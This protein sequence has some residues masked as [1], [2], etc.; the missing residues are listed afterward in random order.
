MKIPLLD[1]K[2]QYQTIKDKIEPA[3]L[4]CMQSGIYI[5]GAQVAGFEDEIARYLGVRNAVSVGNGTDALIIA[6]RAAGVGKGDEVITTPFT[7]IATADAVTAL[8]AVP[9]F[10]DIREDTYNL[11]PSR[12]EEKITARTKAILPVHIFGQPADMDE[13]LAIAEKHKIKVVEDACQAIGAEYKGRKTGTFGSLACFSFFPTKN[14]GC[15]GDGGL[16]T[17]DDDRLAVICRALR[18]HGGGKKGAAAR[19]YMA[20]RPHKEEEAPADA[21]YNPFKYYNYLTG[22]NSRLDAV[23]AA[24]LRVKLPHLDE[25]NRLRARNAAF[26]RERLEGCG[27]ILPAVAPGV[28]HIWHQFALRCRDKNGMIAFLAGKG[29]SAGVFYPVPLHLQKA[30]DFL[31]YKAGD[32]PAAET[33][34]SQTVCLPIY[35]E[36]TEEELGYIADCV[37][38]FMKTCGKP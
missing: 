31:R 9:V 34:T 16:I 23:Q 19:D 29:I 28:T 2:R 6:L 10:A 26:Y 3:V 38:E 37:L 11:D 30:F 22:Y 35:P 7:Y 5:Q 13:I 18:E 24:V 27:V 4:S 25:W 21:A 33:I 15:F 20:G 12:I 17:T 1:L 14:L 32:L 36:L 8:G